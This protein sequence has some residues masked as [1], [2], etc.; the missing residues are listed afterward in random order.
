MNSKARLYFWR[1]SFSKP[2]R[3]FDASG[4]RDR[5]RD[6]AYQ[7]IRQY[8]PI[9]LLRRPA[10][11]PCAV[12]VVSSLAAVGAVALGLPRTALCPSGFHS[13]RGSRPS[14]DRQQGR[15]AV[16]AA[17]DWLLT[18]GMGRASS[19][20][21]RGCVPS[22]SRAGPATSL[23][24]AA[25]AGTGGPPRESKARRTSRSKRVSL[26]SQRHRLRCRPMHL[27]R[28]GGLQLTARNKCES[29][30]QLWSEKTQQGRRRSSR[31]QQHYMRSTGCALFTLRCRC[32]TLHLLCVSS[33]FAFLQLQIS[34]VV[35]L[36]ASNSLRTLSSPAHDSTVLH[37][38]IAA[39]APLLST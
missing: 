5:A 19:G 32:L 10:H 35:V 28:V 13:A 14:F 7:R 24:R 37:N 11:R 12:A 33:A 3:E 4:L 16:G 25:G 20:C 29:A 15:V 22:T 6:C 30:R 21:D 18:G 31:N 38:Y 39:A 17:G 1:R 8:F 9:R 34:S 36:A 2:S 23:E 26:W 27:I